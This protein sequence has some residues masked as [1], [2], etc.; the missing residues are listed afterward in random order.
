MKTSVL[1]ILALLSMFTS[2][3]SFTQKHKEV[4]G[5]YSNKRGAKLEIFSDNQGS[6][7][8]ASLSARFKTK[9]NSD[10]SELDFYLSSINKK[11]NTYVFRSSE[12]DCDDPGCVMYESE[13][14]MKKN[15]KGF[16]YASIITDVVVDDEDL[17]VLYEDSRDQV[18]ND[19]LIEILNQ[20]CKDN[21]GKKAYLEDFVDDYKNSVYCAYQT[22]S[23]LKKVIL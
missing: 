17:S 1:I 18:S 14:L 7:G 21:H 22:K 4:I 15:K 11:E 2:A 16:Y 20:G 9:K 10:L 8:K 23:F 12:D 13:L 3:E 5:K 6:R 19:E